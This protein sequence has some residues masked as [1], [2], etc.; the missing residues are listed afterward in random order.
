MTRGGSDITYVGLTHLER[1]RQWQRANGGFLRLPPASLDW[2]L[3]NWVNQCRTDYREG[4]LSPQTAVSFA[5]LGISMDPRKDGMQPLPR[6]Y[7][8][9]TTA[10]AVIRGDMFR[11]D[12]TPGAAWRISSFVVDWIARTKKLLAGKPDCQFAKDLRRMIPQF[13]AEYLYTPGSAPLAAT[14][15]S[16]RTEDILVDILEFHTTRLA[17]PSIISVDESERRLAS[18]LIRWEHDILGEHA[19]SQERYAQQGLLLSALD[20]AIKAATPLHR[21]AQ[22]NWWSACA[23]TV[24]SDDSIGTRWHSRIY[25]PAPQIWATRFQW[26]L[27]GGLGALAKRAMSLRTINEE[28]TV[29]AAVALNSRQQAQRHMDAMCA[30]RQDEGVYEYD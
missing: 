11:E 25:A 4:T 8:A 24:L 9:A 19:L 7:D 1:V 15:Q 6:I 12:M 13:Y 29:H 16:R 23:M 3:T 27:A 21:L 30:V 20:A 22:W 5:A 2:T 14:P 17:L 26:D 18:W 10:I 28:W